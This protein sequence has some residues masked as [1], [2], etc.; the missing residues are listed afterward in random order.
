MYPPGHPHLTTALLG[1]NDRIHTLLRSRPSLSIGVARKQLVIEGVATDPDNP[2]L[3]ELALKLHRHQL[4][5]VK[6]MPD[7]Q[8]HEIAEFLALLVQDPHLTGESLGRPTSGDLRR[9]EN[10]WLFPLAYDQLE[11]IEAEEGEEAPGAGDRGRGAQLW[12]GLA[13]AAL[14]GDHD[15]PPPQHAAAADPSEVAKAIE[16]HGRETTYDQVIVGYLLQIADELKTEPNPE[17]SA[18]NRRVSRLVNS[19]NPETLKRLLDMGG[20]VGQRQR[21]VL[22]ATQGMAVNAVMELVK[23]AAEASS[24]NMS[25]SLVRLL[26]KL[27]VHAEAGSTETRQGADRELREHVRRLVSG[28]ELDDPNP[29][30]YTDILEGMA[31]ARPAG[32]AVLPESPPEPE[33]LLQ[34]AIEVDGIGE[35]VMRAADLL[36]TEGRFG[37]A[38][39]VLEKAPRRNETATILFDYLV[40]AARLRTLLEDENTIDFDV[41]DRLS[42]R[43]GAAAAEPLLDAYAGAEQRAVRRK[44]HDRVVTIGA[45]IG[46]QV[47]ARLVDTP[48][49]VQRNMLTLL[50]AMPTWPPGFD[51]QRWSEHEDPRV[52]REAYR[53]LW[54]MEDRRAT[55][56]I[57]AVAD[58]DEGIQRMA[59]AAATE[60]CPPALGTTLERIA[61]DTLQEAEVRALA[62]RA[63]VTLR[64][65]ETLPILLQLATAR[66]GLLRRLSL[67]EKGPVMLAALAGLPLFVQEG[68]DAAAAVALA[69]QSTD[70]QIRGAVRRKG[71]RG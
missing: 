46:P 4:G 11:L 59:L 44:L 65:T 50:G 69:T 23:A 17:H 29:H 8:D 3:R 43:L 42:R 22:D 14:A 19:L 52:R 1:F 40:T 54:R 28:W 39:D 5:A 15:A 47:V 9:W 13:S 18:L 2:L 62:L 49:Y 55:A 33:R 51:P 64:R 36:V 48:W 67:R 41:V 24:Q 56:L 61:T 16:D 37:V 27:A 32:A 53:L 45:G 63:V 7:I 25:T 35:T 58:P 66:K 26:N 57:E 12:V 34:M 68:K 30:A 60:G 31:R 6:I 20:S 21:F 10:L 38:L 71:G 70:A